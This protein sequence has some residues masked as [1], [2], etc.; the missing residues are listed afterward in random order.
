LPLVALI[1]VDDDPRRREHMTRIARWTAATLG[2]TAVVATSYA[3]AADAAAE[4]EIRSAEQQ[5]HD[6]YVKHD[7]PLFASLYADDATFTYNTGEVVNKAER[8]KR[9]TAPF[10]DL[11][12]KLQSIR[13]YGDLAIVNDRSDYSASNK[14]HI[15]IQITRVWLK[16]NGKWQVVSFQST[17]IKNAN[18][19]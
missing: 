17:L 6:A 11:S 15:A 13:I 5:M 16:R 7:V 4:R 18:G 1:R 14:E 2:V 9:F 3:F 12:D 8:V 10:A 19:Q